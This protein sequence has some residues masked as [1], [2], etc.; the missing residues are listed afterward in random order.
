MPKP[1]LNFIDPFAKCSARLGRSHLGI[2]PPEVYQELEKA[3]EQSL[4]TRR[5]NA[6][7]SWPR[8]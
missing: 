7:A 5:T 4:E 8:A 3:E 2:I 1:M 6:T